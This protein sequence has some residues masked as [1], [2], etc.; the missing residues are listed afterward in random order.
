MLQY[1]QC[2][3]EDVIT[4]NVLLEYYNAC[5]YMIAYINYNTSE[6]QSV[7]FAHRLKMILLLQFIGTLCALLLP[8]LINVIGLVLSGFY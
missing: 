6:Q 2:C 8:L 3:F 5:I 1:K 4:M 7:M